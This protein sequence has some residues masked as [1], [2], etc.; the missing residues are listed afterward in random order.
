MPTEREVVAMP[1]TFVKIL[2]RYDRESSRDHLKAAA[3][4]SIL[5]ALRWGNPGT[6]DALLAIQIKIIACLPAVI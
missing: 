2:E 3:G 6:F 4:Q 1:N 5:P